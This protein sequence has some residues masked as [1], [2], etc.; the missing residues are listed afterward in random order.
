LTGKE[1]GPL[2]ASVKRRKGY[3]KIS[4]ELREELLDWI[5]NHDNVIASPIAKDAILVLKSET[6]EKE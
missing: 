1:E 2:W 6:G 4:P 3:S 5:A